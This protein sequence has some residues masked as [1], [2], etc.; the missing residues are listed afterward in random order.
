ME[1]KISI[2]YTSDTHGYLFSVDYA[3]GKEKEAGLI[4]CIEKYQKDGNTLMIDG[5]D[6][7][8]GSPFTMYTSKKQLAPHP[9]A[10]VLNRG[11]YDYVTLGNHDFN[12]GEN[13]LHGYLTS[14]EAKCLCGN[15]I[16][17]SGKL[18]VHQY[19]IK[20]LENGLRVGIVGIVTDYVNVWERPEN[21]ANLEIIDPFEVAKKNLEAIKDKVD[22][23]ICLYHGGFECDLGTGKRLTESTENIG[24][25]ICSELDFN[26][27]LTGHQH[28]Q[29]E[30]MEIAGTY[31]VQPVANA[32]HYLYIEGT[33]KEDGVV[34]T[35]QFQSPSYTLDTNGLEVQ[36]KLE[37]EVQKW[38]DAPVGYLDSPLLPEDKVIMALKGNRIPDFFNQIQL[39]VT[40]AQISCTS[41]ANNIK[42]FQQEVSV[43]DVVSTYVYPNTLITI[44][45]T[46]EVLKKALERSA[47]YLDLDQ[48]GRPKVSDIFLIPKVEHYSYDF[49][50]GITYTADLRKPVGER[51][52]DIC[53]DGKLIHLSDTFTLCMNSYRA[54]G[55]GG[56]EMYKGCPVVREETVDVSE[57]IINYLEEH[58]KVT[59]K[60][61]EA[62]VFL[63]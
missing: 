28:M 6:T 26:L 24:Y 29:I 62:P 59:V 8:Q 40:G 56:Y 5:G 43:R 25:R 14:L 58:K 17:K 10:S 51:V 19:D 22:M 20:V 3:T 61:Y 60:K 13:H 18:P 37:Q 39:S 33:M 21:I 2:Y 47:S 32:E 57:L 63:C 52:F 53:Y 36:L 30:G 42:G 41:L 50:A 35:S 54:T 27:L 11:K 34:F 16:D 49:F 55:A 1:K 38:L 45:V 15:V 4:S 44:E 46:G 31:I 9:V 48:E 7:I 12:Y 23:T